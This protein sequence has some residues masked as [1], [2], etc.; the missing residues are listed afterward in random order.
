[1]GIDTPY[2][3]GKLDRRILIQVYT[4][5]TGT[6][7]ERTS[8]WATHGYRWAELLSTSAGE[9]IDGDR[10][11]VATSATFRIRYDSAITEKYR[12]TFNS[13]IYNIAGINIIDRNRFMDLVCEAAE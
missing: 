4:E 3:A 5:S 13:K 1:M 10:L 6:N 12:V 2:D 8:T 7:G 11:L 9:T